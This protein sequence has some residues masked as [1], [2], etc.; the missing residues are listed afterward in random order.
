MKQINDSGKYSD[1]IAASLKDALEKFKA[2]Q[3]W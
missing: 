2:T 1:D 3:T